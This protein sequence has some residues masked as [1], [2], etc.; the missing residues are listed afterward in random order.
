MNGD[1]MKVA[2]YAR[3]STG[4][5]NVENQVEICLEYCKRQGYEVYKVYRDV[6]S[7]ATSSRPEF[8]MLLADMRSYRF[9]CIVV[10]KLDRIGR[11]LKHLL[12]LFDEL[13]RFRH[14]F[15]H[16]YSYKLDV[17]KVKLILQNALT[18]EGIY[19]KEVEKFLSALE[20]EAK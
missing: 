3:V 7:G 1:K 20:G 17:E 18:L 16:A 8:N 6:I 12:S 11:S 5:Q 13:M 4:D 10:T 14:V 9:G 19:K 15:R 2:I